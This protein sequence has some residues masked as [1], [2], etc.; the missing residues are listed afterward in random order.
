MEVS[1]EERDLLDVH[2]LGAHCKVPDLHVLDHALAKRSH[3][4]AP[5][6]EGLAA[7]NSRLMVSQKNAQ[8]EEKLEAAVGTTYRWSTAVAL[9]HTAPRFSPTVLLNC[10]T[11]GVSLW[12]TYRRPFDLIFRRAK[13]EEWSALADYF[14]T[15]L[16]NGNNFEPAVSAA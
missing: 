12:P 15:F 14:R 2:L 10:A 1:R 8:G 16:L 5:L 7:A 13:N 3:T 6:R 11:D 4:R 9:P